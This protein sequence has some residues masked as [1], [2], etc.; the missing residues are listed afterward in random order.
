[1]QVLSRS[2]NTINLYGTRLQQSASQSDWKVKS[3]GDA[4]DE[5]GPLEKLALR[6]LLILRACI[7]M[8]F[9]PAQTFKYQH[10]QDKEDRKTA[11]EKI[12]SDVLTDA[13]VVGLMEVLVTQYFVL[14]GSDLRD[15]ETE[16][17]EWE[18]REEEI[19]DAWEFSV[20]ACSEKLFLDIVHQFQASTRASIATSF[21]PVC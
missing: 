6:A 4:D 9:N 19:A 8:V 15:W 2:W 12:H 5:V 10:P 11:V 1:M 17:D 14:R 7:K 21:S 3:G 16:P 18:K 20:R 13:F